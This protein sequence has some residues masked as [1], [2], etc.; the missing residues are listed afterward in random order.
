MTDSTAS[1]AKDTCDSSVLMKLL[2]TVILFYFLVFCHFPLTRMHCQGYNVGWSTIMVSSEMAVIAMHIVGLRKAAL[3]ISIGEMSGGHFQ[4]MFTN[5]MPFW[6]GFLSTNGLMNKYLLSAIL[7]YLTAPAT[8][9]VRKPSLKK[10]LYAMIGGVVLTVVLMIA[11]G[12]V[13]FDVILVASPLY[14]FVPLC[15]TIRKK[16]LNFFAE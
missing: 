1:D 13:P 5:G 7:S 15:A 2:H 10:V 16:L 3:L 12:T 14:M 8:T 11:L 9:L 4:H 6:E